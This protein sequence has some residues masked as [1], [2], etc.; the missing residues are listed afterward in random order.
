MKSIRSGR[1][2]GDSLYLQ[3]VARALN[4]PLH[5]LSDWPELFKGYQVSPHSRRADLVSH[6]VVRKGAKGTSQFQDMCISVGL[7]TTVDLRLDWVP[8]PAGLPTGKPIVCVQLPR[9]PMGRSDGF[10][11]CLLPDCQA[12]QTAINAIAGKA[13]IVQIGAGQPLFNFSGIDIDL[14]NRTTVA[15]LLDVACAAYAFIGY[16][17]FIVPLAESLSKPAL[18]VW[19]RCGLNH[20][21]AFLNRVPPAKILHKPT[22]KHVIDDAAKVHIEGAANG[23]LRQ[24]H[25]TTEA[26]RETDCVSG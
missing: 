1:G 18:L 9:A 5:I 3:S 10:G 11:A 12:I 4:Q 16:P 23:L 13:T 20:R 19:S 8:S 14:S 21:D 7:P 6:Y 25:S 2:L 15:Q 17:S 24:G 26:G 22:S